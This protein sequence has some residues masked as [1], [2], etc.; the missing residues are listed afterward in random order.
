MSFPNL[1]RSKTGREQCES[2]LEKY[3]RWRSTDVPEPDGFPEPREVLSDLEDLGTALEHFGNEEAT[4]E[5]SRGYDEGDSSGQ[6]E[7][8]KDARYDMEGA[9]QELDDRDLKERMLN[10]CERVFR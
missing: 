1:P 6:L 2:I 4:D 8:Y 3:S 9:I 7:G 5:Y 10:V